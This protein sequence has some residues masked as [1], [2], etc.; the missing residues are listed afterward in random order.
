MKKL[1]F[2][3]RADL[4]TNS[5]AKKLFTL[6]AQKKTNLA[7]SADV[8]SAKELIHL[9]ETLGPEICLLKTHIDIISDFHPGLITILQTLATKHQFLLFEDRKFADIGNTVLHQYQDGIYHI[10]DWA[11]LIN[12]HLL[13]GEGIITGLK[14]IGMQQERGLLLIAQMSS[15]GNL[16]DQRYTAASVAMALKHAEFV[17]GFICQKTS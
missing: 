9:A 11:H 2:Q 15:A 3:Q 7:L 8:T 12:A 17:I 1:S 5:T 13:P 6:I 10:A 4:C 14:K 16:F